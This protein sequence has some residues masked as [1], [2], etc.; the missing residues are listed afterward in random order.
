MAISLKAAR[1]NANLTQN[2][3]AGILHVAQSTLWKWENGSS[4]PDARQ[5]RQM[6]DLYGQKMDDIFLPEPLSR[7]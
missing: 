1:V 2:E 3:A 5:F 7:T 6:C 4:T